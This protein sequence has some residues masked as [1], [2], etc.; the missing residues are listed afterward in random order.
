MGQWAGEMIHSVKDLLHTDE[1]FSLDRNHL[2]QT[3]T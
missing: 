2:S 3:W 1:D